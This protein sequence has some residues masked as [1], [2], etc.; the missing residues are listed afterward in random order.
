[1]PLCVGGDACSAALEALPICN[2]SET[3]AGT[4]CSFRFERLPP[5]PALLLAVANTPLPGEPAV[6]IN[7]NAAQRTVKGRC[8]LL[9]DAA[10]TLAPAAGVAALVFGDANPPPA[11]PVCDP[12]WIHTFQLALSVNGGCSGTAKLSSPA[13]AAPTDGGGDVAVADLA[14]DVSC[15]RR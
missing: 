9:S 8:A 13:R 10:P 6:F 15:A 1:M 11:T 4:T 5:V 14:F 2:S 3:A 7:T 12:S